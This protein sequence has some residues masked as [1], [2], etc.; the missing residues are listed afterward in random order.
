MTIRKL[1]RFVQIT[2][3]QDVC[4]SVVLQYFNKTAEQIIEILP[5]FNSYITSQFSH[6]QRW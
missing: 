4:L 3:S 1:L 2:L 5:V 6:P